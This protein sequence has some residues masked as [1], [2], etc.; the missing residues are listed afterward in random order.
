MD[1]SQK[2]KDCQMVRELSKALLQM[3]HIV[4]SHG[5]FAIANNMRDV[6]AAVPLPGS[7]RWRDDG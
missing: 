1:E 6:M 5:E 3:I 2:C 4:Q 7:Q